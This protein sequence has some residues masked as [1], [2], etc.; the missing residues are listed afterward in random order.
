MRIWGHA[1]SAAAP[2]LASPVRS[3]RAPRKLPQGGRGARAH[4]QRR[5]PWHRLA[6]EMARR[7][8]VSPPTAWRDAHGGGPPFPA[9]CVGGAVD[10]RARHAAAA[11]A[12]GRAAGGAE[13]RADLRAALSGSAA[14]AI[15]QTAPRDPPLDRYLAPAGAVSDGGR[16]SF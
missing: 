10:D 9:L 15:S 6:G 16:R 8:A 12:A 13:R 1:D 11:R 4:R 14:A 5:Q 3:R 2:P 7:R